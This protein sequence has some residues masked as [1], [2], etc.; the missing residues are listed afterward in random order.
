MLDSLHNPVRSF[1]SSSM[2]Q[3]V[4]LL[5]FALW[6]VLKVLCAYNGITMNWPEWQQFMVIHKH[7]GRWRSG[8]LHTK[9]FFSKEISSWWHGFYW[10]GTLVMTVGYFRICCSLKRGLKV[11]NGGSGE[12]SVFAF[13]IETSSQGMFSGVMLLRT[14]NHSWVVSLRV[15]RCSRH[16]VQRSCASKR[17]ADPAGRKY[18]ATYLQTVSIRS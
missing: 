15:M 7:C 12:L 5:M 4:H 6:V 16:T 11:C 17:Q 14:R 13:L 10:Q 3:D 9:K 1:V 8:F 2:S 18:G